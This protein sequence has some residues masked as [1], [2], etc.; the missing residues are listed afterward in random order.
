MGIPAS[1]FAQYGVKAKAAATDRTRHSFRL[2]QIIFL[3][4]AI[5]A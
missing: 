3:V 2:S 4:A 5:S 1:A